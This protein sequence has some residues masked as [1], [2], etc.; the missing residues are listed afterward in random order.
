MALSDRADGSASSSPSPERSAA[1]GSRRLFLFDIDGTLLKC[2]PQIRAIFED[3]L[4]E[5]FGTAGAI[6]GY[7]FA[8]K[9]DHGIV[10]DL[11]RQAGLATERVD[12]FFPAFRDHYL[13]TLDDRL[14]GD[15]MLLMP[16]LPEVLERLE[17]RDDVLLG[18][19]TGNFRRGAAIKLSRLG[20]DRF[21][22][23]GA[24]GDD[25]ASRLD[26][27]P[28]ALAA[29]RTAVGEA[30]AP[31]SALIV[32]DSVLDVA[33]ARAHGVGCVAVT[34]GFANRAELVAAGA[35]RVVDDLLEAER[36]HFGAAA[37]SGRSTTGRV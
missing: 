31:E 36:R 33:C 15:R 7:D 30:I 13:A 20:L 26:L 18:L 21:F 16:G 17:A 28:V 9:T 19:L 32:G 6:D 2:G 1:G 27:P 34:T 14:D 23:F 5:V 12:E 24:F 8:G 10:R 22:A 35:E 3:A 25:V 37:P 29:A 4:V 11:M